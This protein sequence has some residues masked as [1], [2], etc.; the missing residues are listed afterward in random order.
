MKDLKEI[1][2]SKLTRETAVNIV[3]RLLQ[4]FVNIQNLNIHFTDI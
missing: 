3:K 2:N 1:L 4:E